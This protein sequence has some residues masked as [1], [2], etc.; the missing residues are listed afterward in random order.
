MYEVISQT[1]SEDFKAENTPLSEWKFQIDNGNIG[2]MMI[3]DPL[4]DSEAIAAER[5]KS[6]FLQN[7]YK[8][9]EVTFE[10]H[11]TDFAKNDTINI[12]G[13]PYLVKAITTTV[14]KTM[15]KTKVKAV[16]YD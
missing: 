13:I 6:E 8:L 14:D 7:S 11:L 15:I 4:I 12:Y 3:S 5:A 9:N 1:I 2:E 10:T 16:R